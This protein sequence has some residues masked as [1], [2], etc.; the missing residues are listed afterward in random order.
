MVEY[1]NQAERELLED[2]AHVL[3]MGD[4]YQGSAQLKKLRRL[5]EKNAKARKQKAAWDDGNRRLVGARVPIPLA[6]SLR[7]AASLSGRSLYRFTV[8][9]LLHEYARTMEGKSC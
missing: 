2:M 3:A 5:M 1:L 6:D 7:K 4:A 8:D 9:A